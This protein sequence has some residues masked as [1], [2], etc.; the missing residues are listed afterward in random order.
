M[1]S[2]GH[3]VTVYVLKFRCVSQ[4]HFF[5]VLQ[6]ESQDSA[7][8]SKGGAEVPKKRHTAAEKE[9]AGTGPMGR[10]DGQKDTRALLTNGRTH[11]PN[12]VLVGP[13]RIPHGR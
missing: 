10:A 12:G 9:P 5:T 6:A 7:L 8:C 2:E 4:F 1:T 3:V 13:Y 11:V